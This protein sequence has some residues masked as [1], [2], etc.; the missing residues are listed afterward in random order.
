MEVTTGETSKYTPAVQFNMIPLQVREK[1]E[2]ALSV[3]KPALETALYEAEVELEIPERY[4]GV[5]GFYDHNLKINKLAYA[6]IEEF[7]L[8]LVR[9]WYKYGQ[10][11]PYEELRPKQLDPH[12]HR[13]ED[14]A[15]VMSGQRSA[16]YLEDLIE[17]LLDLDLKSIF[18]QE[19]FEFLISNYEDWDPA[20]YT[21][22]Y[23]SSTRIIKVLEDLHYREPED[24]L[25]SVGNLES[26]FKDA[27]I[28]LQYELKTTEEFDDEIHDHTTTF[29]RSL[30]DSL[31]RIEET[32]SLDAEKEATLAKSRRVYHGFVWPWTALTISINRAKGPENRIDEF[33]ESGR[34]ML[35]TDKEDFETHLKG[36][37]T[38]LGEAGLLAEWGP[39][40][41]YEAS[42]PEAIRDL[43]RA[44]LT[45]N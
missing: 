1:D 32:S 22:A 17:F 33:R 25:D 38:E 10:Y 39:N 8:P 9:T 12:N 42:V 40:Q 13:Y 16:I 11:E 31:R 26:E 18:E 7:D 28:D 15:H 5:R 44:A 27:S 30:E 20:P 23:I 24:I 14:D 19:V 2:Q 36:W 29:L 41:S 6:A 43:Q 3:L 37:T 4:T 21:D 34:D 45:N 35:K